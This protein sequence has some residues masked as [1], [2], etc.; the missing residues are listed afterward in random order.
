MKVSRNEL[1]ITMA[2]VR[3]ILEDIKELEAG[4]DPLNRHSVCGSDE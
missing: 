1:G 2:C 3:D 4:R